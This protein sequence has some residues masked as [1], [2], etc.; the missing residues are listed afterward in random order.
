M[1]SFTQTQTLLANE[2]NTLEFTI[3]F[4]SKTERLFKTFQ[5]LRSF[6]KHFYIKENKV[7]F[8]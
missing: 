5:K 6:S 7:I 1:I 3:R 8:L 4:Y 2:N